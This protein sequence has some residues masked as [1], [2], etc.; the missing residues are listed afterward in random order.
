MNSKIPEYLRKC[1]IGDLEEAIKKIDLSKLDFFE[2]GDL[3]GSFY[4]ELYYQLKPISDEMEKKYLE[5]KKQENLKK[6]S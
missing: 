6:A 4:D 5:M 1:P 2:L 3:R